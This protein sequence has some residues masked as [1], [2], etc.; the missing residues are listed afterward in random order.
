[1]PPTDMILEGVLARITFPFRAV[2]L[3]FGLSDVRGLS[4]Q[5]LH[6]LVQPALARE[7]ALARSPSLL[8]RRRCLVKI[9]DISSKCKT[10]LVVL[11]L[12]SFYRPHELIPQAEN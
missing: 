12:C 7:E 3:N 8:P 11:K 6:H 5:P 4:I 1:M 9:F 10:I 2:F